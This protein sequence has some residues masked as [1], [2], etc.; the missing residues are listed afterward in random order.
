MLQ[1]LRNTSRRIEHEEALSALFD[2]HDLTSRL[3]EQQAW[4]GRLNRFSDGLHQRIHGPSA[5]RHHHQPAG[6]LVQPVHDSSPGYGAA[7]TVIRQ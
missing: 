7:F 4:M 5:A 3:A 2:Q 6:V 1:L